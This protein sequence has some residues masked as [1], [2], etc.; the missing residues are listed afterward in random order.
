MKSA[1]LP[2]SIL[3]LFSLT[4]LPSCVMNLG[5]GDRPFEFGREGDDRACD[6]KTGPM[7]AG[8]A[9]AASHSDASYSDASYSD[10][11]HSAA[12]SNMPPTA[13]GGLPSNG[14]AADASNADALPAPD[15]ASVTAC[16][17]SSECLNGQT[18][19]GGY[20]LTPCAAHC[21]C[22][23]GESCVTGYCAIV[24]LDPSKPCTVD[25]E[26]PSGAKCLSGFCK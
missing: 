10:A 16:G 15:D 12:P 20:C 25:C 9:D 26:C 7:W 22:P 21:Q 1:S 6:G 14:A 17:G 13:D 11:S 3:V 24:P 4:S 8:D 5:G 19:V 23:A 2:W 18:C